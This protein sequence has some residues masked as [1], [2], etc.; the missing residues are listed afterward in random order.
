M[1][2]SQIVEL[3]ETVVIQDARDGLLGRLFGYGAMVR[4][5]RVIG[6]GTTASKNYLAAEVTQQ[7]FLLAKQKTF[8]REPAMNVIIELA[9]RV[10]SPSIH[11]LL[12]EYPLKMDEIGFQIGSLFASSCQT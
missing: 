10:C 2:F 8:L 12:G 3:I 9:Q 1:P 6:E 7:L 5:D 4:A 11:V